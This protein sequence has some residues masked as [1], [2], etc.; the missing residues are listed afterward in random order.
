MIKNLES[1]DV[2]ELTSKEISKIN[3]GSGASYSAG[4]LIGAALAMPFLIVAAATLAVT[5]TIY[6]DYRGVSGGG[7]A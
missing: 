1:F 5:S 6:T 7:Y 4:W 2:K 3:G